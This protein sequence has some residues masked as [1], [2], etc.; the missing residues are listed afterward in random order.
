ML[1][2]RG[3]ALVGNLAEILLGLILQDEVDQMHQHGGCYD[4][5][6][7]H[8]GGDNGHGADLLPWQI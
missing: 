6:C 8:A 3:T 4:A 2:D 7:H 1:F 5:D